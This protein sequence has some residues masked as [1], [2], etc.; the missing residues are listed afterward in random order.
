MRL[1][2][3]T[4]P[5]ALVASALL[6]GACAKR[7]EVPLSAT[8]SEDDDTYCRAGGKIAAGSPEYVNCIKNRDAQRANA[9]ARADK[10][11]QGLAEYMLNNPVRP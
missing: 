8:L 11:Q 2:T 9:I 7:N 5:L 4:L 10:K 3:L 1:T 6:L